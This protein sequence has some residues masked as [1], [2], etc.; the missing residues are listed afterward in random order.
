MQY[1]I[2][3]IDLSNQSYTIE[4]I[5]KDIIRKYIG[6][7]GLGSYLLYRSV[8]AKADPLGE[9]N[10]VIFTAGPASGTKF[11]F[12]SKVNLNTK[13][14]LTN[15]YLY[16]ISSGIL[17]EQMVKAGLMA[18]DLKGISESP[19]YLRINNQKVEFKDAACLWGMETAK[20]QQVMLGS[21][22]PAKTA[23]VAIGPAGEELI[24]FASV[25][26]AGSL[27]RCFGRGGAGCVMGSKKLKGMIVSG[28]G[29]VS[30]ADKAGFE[31][32][33]RKIFKQL[34]TSFRTWADHWR[35]Y[36]T[37]ADL[38][39][40]N[41]LGIIPTR[42]WQNGQF[43]NWRGID[44]STTPIGW[45]DQGHACAPYCP[46]PGIR[47][48]E[49]QEGPYKG[50]RS[51]VEWEAIYAFGSTCGI[52]KMEAIIAASQICDEFGVDNMTAGVTI[53][54]AMECFEKGL[55]STEDTDGIEL[56][57]GND[58]A[59]IAVLKKMVAQ[60]GFGKKIAF[61]TKRLSEEIKGSEG[62][63][64]HSKGMEF[65][66]YECR[67]LNGQALQFAT[68]PRGGCHHAHGLP[69][70]I[71][72]KDGTR[73]NIEGK[74]EQVKNAAISRILCDSLIFC[75]FPGGLP[76]FSSDVIAETVSSLFGETWSANDVNRVGE[77]VMCQE[78]LFN[79]REAGLT[80]K[81]D[82]LPERLLSEP[83]PDGPTKG[84]VVPLEALKDDFYT[85]MRYDLLTGNPTDAI[86]EKFE[87]GK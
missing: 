63:A 15:I 11:P 20:A 60:E 51:S 84:A 46:T 62:F 14:P 68:S 31:A 77:R 86:L 49:I 76:L 22:S 40:T 23:T 33:R 2:L 36:E 85:A 61:G 34:K 19:V 12:S 82:I 8:P 52:D 26:S 32:A 37:A 74:G 69:A 56:R 66:G 44:K 24:K 17:A 48:V 16:S 28:D 72:I 5:P 64:M 21:L 38:E 50:A 83:K 70:R 67:G 4:E 81:D 73:L 27:Y 55:I 7:R 41:E 71:E 13:S 59:M 58:A 6:G 35:Q 53:G 45:P 39:T 54:F 78:R 29:E 43:E 9:E 3:K 25:F 75:T 30:I 47:E 18:I 79:I 42:N 1:L 65:G 57:F 10:H 87:I 80:R